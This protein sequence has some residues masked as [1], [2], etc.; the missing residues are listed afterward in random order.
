[1]SSAGGAPVHPAALR[2]R[3]VHER[4]DEENKADPGQMA[5]SLRSRDRASRAA[6]RACRVTPTGALRLQRRYHPLAGGVVRGQEVLVLPAQGASPRRG[7]SAWAC[8][9]RRSSCNIVPSR[10]SGTRRNA[11]QRSSTPCSATEWIVAQ[12]H[13]LLRCGVTYTLRCARPPAGP[14]PCCPCSSCSSRCSRPVSYR[15][16]DETTR[17][18]A[19]GCRSSTA[20][21]MRIAGVTAGPQQRARIGARSEGAPRRQRC[22]DA[23]A[24]ARQGEGPDQSAP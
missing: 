22:G 15:A 18:S 19:A 2:R 5:T 21:R 7:V 4:R 17:A 24:Q 14:L 20:R 1:M 12:K 8:S 13:N 23:C 16:A 10:R 6:Q 11:T 3:T 9:V